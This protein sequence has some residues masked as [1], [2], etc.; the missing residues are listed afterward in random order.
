MV[1]TN[2][3]GVTRRINLVFMNLRIPFF[4]NEGIVKKAEMKKKRLIEKDA[5]IPVNAERKI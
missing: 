1:I 5:S 3:K 4:S 2:N